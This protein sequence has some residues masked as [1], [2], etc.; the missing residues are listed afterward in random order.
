M[1]HV[2]LVQADRKGRRKE[3][4]PISHLFFLSVLSLLLVTCDEMLSVG[5]VLSLLFLSVSFV[6]LCAV[7]DLW[8]MALVVGAHVIGN[9]KLLLLL[10][11]V[12]C[13]EVAVLYYSM[14]KPGKNSTITV[15]QL[16]TSS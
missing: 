2:L 12:Q 8:C 15:L 7:S 11:I 3:E 16:T 4:N 14:A 9:R 13:T 6:C 1:L 5:R 10:H